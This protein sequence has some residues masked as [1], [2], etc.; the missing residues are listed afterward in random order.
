M[1]NV[2]EYLQTKEIMHRDLKPQNIMLDSNYNVKVIDFG[3]ARRINEPPVEEEEIQG[4]Q[5]EK[6]GRQRADTFVG[7]VNYLSPEVINMSE[8][9]CAI[10]IWALGCML[11]K[12]FFG[13]CMFL[14]L[15]SA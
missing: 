14:F 4:S 12:M 6:G 8:Q 3:D 1:V 9:T 2:V 15:T 11:F 5:Y 7:T 13:Q 10:D